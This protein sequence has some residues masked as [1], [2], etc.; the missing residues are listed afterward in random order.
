L[1][2]LLL[3]SLVDILP[4][5]IRAVF[6][7]LWRGLS[8]SIC[9]FCLFPVVLEDGIAFLFEDAELDSSFGT[10]VRKGEVIP[11]GTFDEL[12]FNV[13]AMS[14]ISDAIVPLAP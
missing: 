12:L 10:V 4:I 13:E 8:S 2:S 3:A 6:S 1:P 9:A 5:R 7:P 14:Q 11:T